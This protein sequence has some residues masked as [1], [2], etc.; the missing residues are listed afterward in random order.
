MMKAR[1]TTSH[2]YDEEA[3]NKIVKDIR[4]KYYPELRY[5]QIQ[6]GVMVDARTDS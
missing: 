5:L 1:N 2:L 3:A 4:D 6:L